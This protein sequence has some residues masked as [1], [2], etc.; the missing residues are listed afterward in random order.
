MID[1]LYLSKSCSG[2][3]SSSTAATFTHIKKF[4]IKLQTS[5]TTSYLHYMYE[6]QAEEPKNYEPHPGISK[7]VI[8]T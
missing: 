3:L 7:Q 2:N 4:S 1:P 6:T 5:S 8:S